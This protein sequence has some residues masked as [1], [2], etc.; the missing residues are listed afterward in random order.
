MLET[1]HTEFPPTR[2]GTAQE[3]CN[4]NV[5]GCTINHPYAHPR[6]QGEG[7]E[8]REQ[9]SRGGKPPRR[10]RRCDGAPRPTPALAAGA[11]GRAEPAAGG[12]ACRG[13]ARRARAAPRPGAPAP[14]DATPRAPAPAPA[15][16]ARRDATR[17]DG[18][19]RPGREPRVRRAPRRSREAAAGVGGAGRGGAAAAT[20][21]AGPGASPQ[22]RAAPGSYLP[23]GGRRAAASPAASCRAR[24][25]PRPLRPAR[26]NPP[27]RAPTPARPC[28]L[29]PARPERENGARFAS[30]SDVSP[31]LHAGA[32]SQWEESVHGTPWAAPPGPPLGPLPKAALEALQEEAAPLAGD[33]LLD[34][35]CLPQWIG[36]P[37]P[38]QESE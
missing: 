1:V 2:A 23:L 16:P 6:L 17:T 10:R 12:A 19:C 38:Q 22:G 7:T 37:A 27:R 29:L 11:P 34:A 9:R 20:P 4:F 8:T 25:G 28:P 21:Q 31:H 15:P 14:R 24:R 13:P 26:R 30:G 33:P 3:S 5:G 36:L 32:T 35:P 18:R